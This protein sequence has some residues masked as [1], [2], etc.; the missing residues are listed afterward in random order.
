MNQDQNFNR[1]TINFVSE[2]EFRNGVMPR[3]KLSKLACEI[4]LEKTSNTEIKE[5]A[6]WELMEATTVIEVLEDLGTSQTTLSSDA[7]AILSK[8]KN[9]DESAFE[10][11]YMAA[12]LSNHE[13]LRNLAHDYL[14]TQQ[15][16]P[17][18]KDK[19]TWHVAGLALFAFTEHV[20]LCKKIITS[21][22]A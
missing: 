3:A 16:K 7:S 20:G 6:G 22:N 5:F 10:K 21:L 8:L 15:V 14:N 11:E 4:A 2:K 12:E 19:E 17:L 13:F 9:L 1:A 18:G